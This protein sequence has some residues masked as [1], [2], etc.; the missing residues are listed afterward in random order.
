MKILVTGG[1]GQ[2][3]QCLRLATQGSHNSYTFTGADSLDITDANAVDSVMATGFDVIVNCAAYTAV[4]RAEDDVDTARAVNATGAGI[5]ARA[6]AA[7]GAWLV[8]VSTDYVFGDTP[9]K[10]PL[11][12]DDA[13]AP[14]GI[15]GATKLEGEKLIE[16]SG[17]KAIVIRTAW[18]YSEHGHN[19]VKTMLGL[20]ASRPRVDVVFDQ[21]GTPTYCPDLAAAI[22]KIIDGDMLEGNEGTYHYS[23]E[24][25]ISW[26]DLARAIGRIAGHSDCDIEPCRSDAFPSKVVRPAYSVLDKALIKKTFGLK[27]PYWA[28]SLEKCLSNLLNK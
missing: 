18:L 17:A 8:H 19:F 10:T 26:F 22:V 12:E 4:D 3:G 6:A 9:A 27:I 7:K 13:T 20:T 24:G 14:T 15:Y 21:V 5:L 28:D 23:N 2:L 1:D 25:A 11:R 16:A